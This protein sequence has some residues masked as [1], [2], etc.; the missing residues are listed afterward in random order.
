MSCEMLPI[1]HLPPVSVRDELARKLLEVL[2]GYSPGSNAW[3]RGSL[4]TN[5]ADQ[6]SD[7]DVAWELANDDVESALR[8]VRTLLSQLKHIECIRIDPE[9]RDS[10]AYRLVFIRFSEF[11]LFWRLDLEIYARLA[12]R[13]TNRRIRQTGLP[14]DWSKAESA[15]ANPVAAV[16]A[17]KRQEHETAMLLLKRALVRVGGS[18]TVSDIS[19]AVWHKSQPI[20]RRSSPI[21]LRSLSKWHDWYRTKSSAGLRLAT[22]PLKIP[23]R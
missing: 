15:L 11:P 18:P 23:K 6:Y 2:C 19:T 8:A 12:Q 4:A 14:S 20:P 1:L 16:K 3:L 21:R 9:F 7:I 5:V 10:P 13:S 17:C 22:F